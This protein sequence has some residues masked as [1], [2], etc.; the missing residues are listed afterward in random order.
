LYVSKDTDCACLSEDRDFRMR[1]YFVETG[2]MGETECGRDGVREIWS[3][4]ET[5]YWREGVKS[6][7][8][9]DHASLSA[10]RGRGFEI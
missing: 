4:G 1:I 8:D 9:F 7:S 5:E 6:I 10:D 3:N 2:S